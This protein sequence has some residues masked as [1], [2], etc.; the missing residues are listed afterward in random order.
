MTGRFSVWRDSRQDREHW[1]AALE[2]MPCREVFAH[3]DYLDLYAGDGDQPTCFFYEDDDGAVIYRCYCGTCPRF[4]SGRGSPPTMQFALLTGTAVP[5]SSLT[6]TQG[7]SSPAS[8]GPTR[9]GRGIML[10]W[11]STSSSPPRM[12]R[13]GPIQDRSFYVH[14][15]WSAASTSSRRNC[16]WITKARSG[17]MCARLCVVGWRPHQT[18]RLRD[19]SASWRSTTPPWSGETQETTLE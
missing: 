14:P 4:R 7:P 16:G 19:S 10:C 8:I 3:P 9:S 15:Q 6:V 11:P 17:L 13:T 18:L 5:S 2:A 12:R 1:R